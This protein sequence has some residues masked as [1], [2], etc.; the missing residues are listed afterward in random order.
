MARYYFH[1]RRDPKLIEDW[2]GG[3]FQ[4]LDDAIAEASKAAKELVINAIRTGR[5]LDGDRVEVWVQGGG[6]V[7]EVALLDV[8]PFR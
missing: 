1:L 4:S 2:E 8:I 5:P 7:G 6:Q 3:E